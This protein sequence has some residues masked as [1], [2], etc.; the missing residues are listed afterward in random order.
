MSFVDK[1]G[2]FDGYDLTLMKSICKNTKIP[3]IINGGARNVRDFSIAI[4]ECGVSAVSAGSMFVFKGP[5]K[6]VLITFPDYEELEKE[7]ENI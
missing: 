6:A 3:V 7:L 2:T 5:H 1:D 4:K